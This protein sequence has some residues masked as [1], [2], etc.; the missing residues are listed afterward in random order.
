[1]VDGA[2]GAAEAAPLQDN[3][4]FISLNKKQLSEG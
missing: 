4:F 3:D 2:Y 1:M